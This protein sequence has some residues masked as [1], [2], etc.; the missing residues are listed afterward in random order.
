MTVLAVGAAS[1]SVGVTCLV[2]RRVPTCRR[3]YLPEGVGAVHCV[4]DVG[5]AVLVKDHRLIPYFLVVVPNEL[6]QAPA[7]LRAERAG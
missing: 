1:R 7:V 3:N 6:P 4:Q 5:V 2:G